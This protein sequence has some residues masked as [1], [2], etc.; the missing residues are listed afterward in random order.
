MC[1]EIEIAH[2]QA[3]LLGVRM[4]SLW[5]SLRNLR[6]DLDRTGRRR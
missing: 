4:V 3:A 6:G 1:D 5:G 2:E